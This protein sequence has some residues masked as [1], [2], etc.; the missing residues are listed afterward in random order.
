V[1]AQGTGDELK[2]SVGGQM[3]EITVADPADRERACEALHSLGCGDP[4]PSE[5]ERLLTLPALD[6]GVAMVTEAA[7][8]LEQAGVAVSELGLRRPTLDDVFLT[9]TG[10]PPEEDGAKERKR[11]EGEDGEGPCPEGA[12]WIGRAE[13]VRR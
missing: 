7:Q 5:M 4:Q 9:L 8:T 13:K 11:A 10:H 6:D 1:I 3:I 12:E 2:D